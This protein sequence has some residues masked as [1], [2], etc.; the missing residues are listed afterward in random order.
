MGV[1]A[2]PASMRS[3]SYACWL[4]RAAAE[5]VVT[6]MPLAPAAGVEPPVDVPAGPAGLVGALVRD[7]ARRL[8]VHPLRGGTPA[9]TDEAQP[10]TVRCNVN[11]RVRPAAGSS[12]HLVCVR[13]SS[14][15]LESSLGI[16]RAASFHGGLLCCDALRG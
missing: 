12:L 6:K 13:P 4:C 16:S 8:P 1:A 2:M 14:L 7:G 3:T 15:S 5:G 9:A 10:I 11:N